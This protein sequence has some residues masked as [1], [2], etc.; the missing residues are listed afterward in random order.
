MA[1]SKLDSKAIEVHESTMSIRCT[2]G[3]HNTQDLFPP[4]FCH[5]SRNLDPS[6]SLI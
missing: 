4:S 1:F 5:A 6:S 3:T 2:L